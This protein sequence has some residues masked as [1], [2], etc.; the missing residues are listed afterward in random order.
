[1]TTTL[2]DKKRAMHA[3]ETAYHGTIAYHANNKS[4]GVREVEGTSYDWFVEED[5]ICV[6]YSTTK[7]DQRICIA[8]Y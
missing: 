7:G 8:Y 1:M 4:S 2:Y 5:T 6:S 3:T